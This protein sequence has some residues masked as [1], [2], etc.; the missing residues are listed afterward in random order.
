MQMAPDDRPPL[1]AP[2]ASRS[3]SAQW[4][5]GKGEQRTVN[6]KQQSVATL[7]PSQFDVFGV[8]LPARKLLGHGGSSWAQWSGEWPVAAGEWPA[9]G[10]WRVASSKLRA[11]SCQL[12]TSGTDAAAAART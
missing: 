2:A 9:S 1:D 3:A 11:A 10:E 12:R 8:P 6:S 5:V 4:P 7:R